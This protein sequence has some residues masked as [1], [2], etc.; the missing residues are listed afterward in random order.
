MLPRCLCLDEPA[1]GAPAPLPVPEDPPIST[2][3][4]TRR[5]GASDNPHVTLV[6][7]RL[8]RAAP[9]W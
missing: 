2:S 4:P 8:L 6:R 7:E 3:Y 1:S 9:T 5:P